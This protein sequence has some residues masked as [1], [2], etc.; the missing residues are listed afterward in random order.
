MKVCVH[1]SVKPMTDEQWGNEIKSQLPLF[2]SFFFFS[3]FFGKIYIS[4]FL[5]PH[6]K[7]NKKNKP[8]FSSE[9]S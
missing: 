9:S 5:Y 8:H 2:F 6:K 7:T 3:F 1:T 4:F